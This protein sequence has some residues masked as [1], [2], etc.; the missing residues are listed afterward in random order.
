MAAGRIA[1]KTF[2]TLNVES[3]RLSSQ[4]LGGKAKEAH[5]SVN[6]KI[7]RPKEFIRTNVDGSLNLEESRRILVSIASLV[8]KPGDYHILI[9]TREAQVALST[10]D[11]YMLG[12]AIASVPAIAHSI[13]A[14]LAPLTE[15]ENARFLELVAR[16]RGALL[17]AFTSFE[18]AIT[19]ILMQDAIDA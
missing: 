10:T 9:D 11:L 5:M 6:I 12:V 2:W 18:E 14:I 16:N 7:V 19:W 15:E 13:T 4:P 1:R 8:D 3:W 17:R